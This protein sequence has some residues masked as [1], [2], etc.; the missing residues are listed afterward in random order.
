MKT[1]ILKRLPESQSIL[2]VYAVIAVMLAGWTITAF[3]RK[4]PSWLLTLNMAE[5]F[6]VFSY[7]MVTNLLESLIVLLLILAICFL[8]PAHILRD[9]FAVRGTLLS[10]GLIGSLMVPMRLYMRFGMENTARLLI[11]ILAVL[12]LTALLLVF[13]SGIGFLRSAVLWVSDRLIVFL[14]VLVPL[15]VFLL[16]Y[17]IFRN[18]I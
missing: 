13:S 3:L 8:L 18:I 15:F 14:F 4:L 11:G 9:D 7:S 12:L 5:I 17:V 6:T 2:Q 10:I 16:V 1:T